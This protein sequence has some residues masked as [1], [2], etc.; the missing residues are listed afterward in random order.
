MDYPDGPNVRTRVLKSGKKEGEIQNEG[1][2]WLLLAL[3]MEKRAMSKGMA[4]RSRKSRG[5]GF[6]SR[7]SRKE[8]SPVDILIFSLV[9]CVLDIYL[10]ELRDNKFALLKPLWLQLFVIATTR[11]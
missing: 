4:P 2:N 3:K 9:R 1:L 10:T 11:N 5:N 7:D 8:R 6:F